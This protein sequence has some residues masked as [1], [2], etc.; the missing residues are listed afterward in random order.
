MA[1][2]YTKKVWV[3]DQ[4]KLSAKNL[5]HLEDGVE[6]VAEA[7]EQLGNIGEVVIDHHNHDNKAILDATTAAFTTNLKQKYDNLENKS[8]VS[9]SA[10]GSTENT[11][12][13][14]TIDGVEYKLAGTVEETTT[15]EEPEEPVVVP[16][17]ETPYQELGTTTLNS[18]LDKGVYVVR[19]AT[20]A[21][22]G[23]A[24]SGILHVNKLTNNKIEQEWLSDTNRAVRIF[25]GDSIRETNFYING[26]K[27]EPNS[28]GIIELSTG[29]KYT[30]H[31]ELNGKI[32]ITGA[33]SKYTTLLLNEVIIN[34]TDNAAIFNTLDNR[35]AIELVDGT[36][37]YINV[38]DN[39]TLEEPSSVG[40]IHS[41]GDLAVYGFGCLTIISNKGHGLKGADLILG[42]RPKIYIDAHH[43]GIHGKS[44]RITEGI[45][46]IKNANDAISGG[47]HNNNGKV[48]ISGGN[49]T[50]EKCR[51]NAF[52]AKAKERDPLP[53]D[54]GL[55]QIYGNTTI[56][57][58]E[59]FSTKK[60][61]NADNNTPKIFDTVTIINESS[62]DM[63][64][65]LSLATYYGSGQVT[66]E[67]GN[68][69]SPSGNV[70][71]L[72]GRD[73]EGT[74]GNLTYSLR[75]DLSNY[76]FVVTTKSINLNFRGVYCNN[77]DTSAIEPFI[78][79][80]PD[81]KRLEL[82]LADNSI[83]FIHKAV[84]ACLSSNKNIGINDVNDAGDI[85]LECPGGYGI[86]APY[87]DTRILNDGARYIENCNVGVY[88]NYLS[89]GED[90]EDIDATKKKDSI[91]YLRNS[92][93]DVEL[94]SRMD[95]SGH[96]KPGKIIAPQ[97]NYGIT[98]I[99][100]AIKS[101]TY[102]SDT[103]TVEALNG[104]VEV[105]G[106]TFARQATIYYKQVEN[107]VV[108]GATLISDLLTS[109]AQPL[110]DNMSTVNVWKVYD[111]HALRATIESLSE[112]VASLRE[113]LTE[114]EAKL[115][116][117]TEA[118][119]SGDGDL[120]L[121]NTTVTEDGNLDLDGLATIDD[122]GS[123]EL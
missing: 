14:I 98:V 65:L 80:Q 84:G 58:K 51:E 96:N 20:D 26:V 90:Y 122:E 94:V 110:T 49:I 16:E 19:N 45:Y 74:A 55:I 18:I 38:K 21:P 105:D 78:E 56:T 50:I 79:Y 59:N 109:V 83:N 46:Y 85:F 106:M 119:I 88:T 81:G 91:I 108:S 39:V 92:A 3:N 40:A 113:R 37:N 99:N 52:Q 5:N 2:L 43:D 102:A 24:N 27:T 86:Y 10:N 17:T 123:L 111:S 7:I 67:D 72:D 62:A 28:S 76:R 60:A 89:L 32:I 31:G 104:N 100:K 115:P 61:F 34:S 68:V 22:T 13:Y 9:V 82:K 75:G 36:T 25:A 12:K 53:T 93:V 48:I 44:V 117:G 97:N 69:M 116:A 6:A 120:S 121:N 30:L 11:V 47:T 29:S 87:G 64:E 112:I 33:A 118:E 1:K 63:P 15:P 73:A 71:Y 57:F 54:N 107:L 70:Y 103:M 114:I 101:D 23:T 66:D 41:E 8:T 77:T 95:S 42:G 4:T 35:L